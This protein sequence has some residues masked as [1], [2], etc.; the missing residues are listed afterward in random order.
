MGYMYI[1][2]LAAQ[3]GYNKEDEGGRDH[4]SSIFCRYV[5]SFYTGG[6]FYWSATEEMGVNDLPGVIV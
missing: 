1:K 6:K 4:S 2:A 5:S 3:Q